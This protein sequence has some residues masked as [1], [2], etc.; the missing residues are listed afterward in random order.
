[1]CSIKVELLKAF[2]VLN[3]QATTADILEACKSLFL[4]SDEY[5]LVQHPF[6]PSEVDAVANAIYE[7]ILC[8]DAPSLREIKFS[9]ERPVEG[10]SIDYSEYASTFSEDMLYQNA[11][12]PFA[13]LGLEEL[14]LALETFLVGVFFRYAFCVDQD[15]ASF[16]VS[17]ILDYI[18]AVA[19]LLSREQRDRELGD[20]LFTTL[21]ALRSLEPGY[22]IE[23]A[24][25]EKAAQFTASSSLKNDVAPEPRAGEA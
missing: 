10:K 1:M 15:R 18:D 5:H 2:Q 4:H 23:K 16:P 9:V 25:A 14:R 24:A 8:P 3:R 20:A 19:I 11:S 13:S 12:T 6:A 21:T 7:Y 17:K 22:R